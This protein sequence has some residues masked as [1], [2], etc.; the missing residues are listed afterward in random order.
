MLL[1]PFANTGHG[2]F[3]S[4]W[5]RVRTVKHSNLSEKKDRYATALA[6]TDLRSQLYKQPLNVTPLNIAAHRAGE[7]SLKGSLMP[8]FRVRMVPYLGTM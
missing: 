1:K 5:A 4:A 3:I 6:L 8:S 7:D 2:T